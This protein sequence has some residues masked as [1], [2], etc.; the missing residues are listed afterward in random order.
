V[1]QS[2]T[3]EIID[4]VCIHAEERVKEERRA[5]LKMKSRCD[6][7]E[8]EVESKISNILKNKILL[9]TAK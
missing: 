1:C 7:R 9:A 8:K 5:L 4:A 6:W 2:T 3:W